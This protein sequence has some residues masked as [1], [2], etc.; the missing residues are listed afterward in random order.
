MHVQKETIGFLLL[1]AVAVLTVIILLVLDPISQDSA[2]HHFSDNGT[3][4]AIPNAFNVLSNIPF[5]I[6]G[7]LGIVKML[8][9]QCLTIVRQNKYAYLVLFLGAALVAF[10][11]AYYHLWP[12]NQTLVWDRLPMTIAFMGLL[13]VIISEFISVKVGKILLLP[14]LALGLLS[15]F[16]WHYTESNGVGDLRLYVF[17]QF[18]PIIAIPIILLT[19]TSL[20]NRVSSYW[21]LMSC[22]LLAKVLEHFDEAIHD[23]LV[24]LSGHSIKH[25]A[26]AVGLYMLL[27]GFQM[28][29]SV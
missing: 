1:F 21:W 25:I 2:Y 24:V 6:V 22:Y 17:V 8:R 28:R 4:L 10:G 7:V 16:Y 18:F 9:R 12:N 23:V 3:V 19:F 26:A 15:V 11:S 5:I 27:R 20:F 29:E 13:S 14:L